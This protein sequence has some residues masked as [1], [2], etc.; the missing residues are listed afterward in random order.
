M[1]QQTSSNSPTLTSLP[2][3]DDI[4]RAVLSNGITVLARANFNSP[5]IVIS[6]YLQAGSL[7]EADSKA[8]LAGFTASAL[9]RGT[10]KRDFQ[11]IY[12]ALESAGASLGYNG[13]THTTGFGGKAL[14]EDLELLLNLLS[15]T[16]R[17]PTFPQDQV[18]RLRT[19][20]MTSLAI[21][22]QDTSQMAH[23]TFDQLVYKGHPY[24]RSEDGYPETVGTITR[25][26]LAEFH[27]SHYGPRGMVV[28]VVGAIEPDQ[29]IKMVSGIFGDWENPQQPIPPELPPVTPLPHSLTEKVTI[30][31]K[32]Q[33]DIILGTP[34]PERR[35]PDFLIAAL[36]NNIL[37]QFGMMGRI[38][39]AVREQAGLAYYAFSSVSGG[40]GPGAWYVSAGVN[41]ANIDTAIGLIQKEIVRFVNEKVTAEELADSKTNFIGRLPLSLET[42]NGVVNA[43]INLEKFELGLDYYE[44]YAELVQAI[45]AD[46]VLEIAQRYLDPDRLGIAVAGP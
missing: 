23:L 34:G 17:Q 32:I 19:Q 8:G 38:G 5:S 45:T 18:E 28:S 46:E 42:N 14:A 7:F 36:G 27:N 16:L 6:G 40:V 15:E 3:P 4:T 22:A 26:D 37:G 20:L 11:E 2:G 33:A 31:G 1:S 21:R 39:E 10:A 12:D 24:G 29:A 43:L 9:M 44:R 13:G 35:S 41:P 30:E 25:D